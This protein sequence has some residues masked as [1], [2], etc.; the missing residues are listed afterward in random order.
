MPQNLQASV[1][2]CKSLAKRKAG[3]FYFSFLTL[4]ADQLRDMCALYAFMRV[5]DDIG[6]DANR[7]IDDRRTALEEWRRKLEAALSGGET[8]HPGL[9]ALADLVMRHKIPHEYLFAVIEG[10]E[11]DLDHRGFETFAELED[12]C[13]LVAGAVGLCCIHVWGFEGEEA[14]PLAIDCGTAFQLTN[15]L[16]DLGEDARTGRI[17]LPEEDLERFGYSPEDLFANKRNSAFQDLMAFEVG[18]AREFYQRAEGLYPH[19]KPAG[20]SIY[21][22]MLGIY[23]GLLDEIE[24]RDFDVYTDRVRLPRWR[25]LWIATGSLIR[26][27]WF[28]RK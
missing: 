5:T 9:P 28:G 20:R 17:Y 24:R 23:G 14:I 2:W 1:R 25:K 7:A 15:I 19:L 12:Y 4:P 21:A 3:N 6:D 10:V 8:D 16:R 27:R 22:A 13:Y 11:K 26:H 18:R